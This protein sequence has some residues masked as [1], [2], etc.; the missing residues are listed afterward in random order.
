MN[1][2]TKTFTITMVVLVL[3][4]AAMFV[5]TN[6]FSNREEVQYTT[7]YV[8]NS[9]IVGYTEITETLFTAKEM[10]ADAVLDGMITNLGNVLG[11]YTKGAM[12]T[13]DILT[14]AS[15]TQ[16]I[17]NKDLIY[18]INFQPTYSGDIAFGDLVDVYQ[19]SPDG[20]IS[21][22][23]ERKKIEKAKTVQADAVTENGTYEAASAL[24]FKVTQKEMMEY[25]SKLASYKFIVL[26]ISAEYTDVEQIA[27]QLQSNTELYQIVEKTETVTQD[28]LTVSAYVEMK[29]VNLQDFLERNTD[30]DG[31]NELIIAG[32]EVVVPTRVYNNEEPVV[33]E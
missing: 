23:Y 29:G 26:P 20:K 21:V 6:F 28:G 3:I 17:S 1:Q 7:V 11:T 5:Y 22:L 24:Y 4:S 12:Y 15:I 19:M 9:D 33:I 18:T 14:E 27:N 32:T 25:Y 2:K 13:G 30:F 16:D 8:A 31:G 10:R